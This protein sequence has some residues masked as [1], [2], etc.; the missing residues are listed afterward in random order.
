[1]RSTALLTDRNF[2]YCICAEIQSISGGRQCPYLPPFVRNKCP[3]SPRYF[4]GGSQCRMHPQPPLMLTPCGIEV[5]LTLSI[6]FRY[7]SLVLSHMHF[8]S[9]A[10]SRSRKTRVQRNSRTISVDNRESERGTKRKKRKVSDRRKK[11]KTES[12]I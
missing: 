9:H 12:E 11:K 4:G 6:S 5:S 3:P 2:A 10:D 8:H 7:I 1:M